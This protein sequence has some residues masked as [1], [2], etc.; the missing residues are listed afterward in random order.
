M[1]RILIIDDEPLVRYTLRQMLETEGHTVIEASNGVEGMALEGS[2]GIDLV[3]SDIIMP[4]MEGIE[5][6]ARFRAQ[7]PDLPIIAISGGGRLR[8]DAP[9]AYAKE[10]GATYTLPKPFGR[11]KVIR[12]VEACLCPT[13]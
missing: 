8:R 11:D 2:A 6:I 4:D 12:L 13:S 9:L 5:T 10:L 3:I 1:A 7:R